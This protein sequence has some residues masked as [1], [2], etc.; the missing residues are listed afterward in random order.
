[1]TY[2]YKIILRLPATF[3]P[4]SSFLKK[5]RGHVPKMIYVEQVQ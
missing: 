4:I 5:L 1:M 3:F 2:L